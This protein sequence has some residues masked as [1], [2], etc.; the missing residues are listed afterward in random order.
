MKRDH[1]QAR[2]LGRDSTEPSTDPE[3]RVVVARDEPYNLI[4]STVGLPVGWHGG[5]KRDQKDD[6]LHMPVL[7][8]DHMC[9][10]LPS[11]H[12]PGHFHLYIDVP[13]TWEQYEN[14]IRALAAG[15]VIEEGY[16][17]VSLQRQ[18]TFVAPRPW[19]DVH[20]GE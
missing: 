15:G 16:A 17:N 1:Y 3:N 7:D 19:K 12:T 14:I 10:L 4:G 5:R 20:D 13:M 6:V 18:A 9:H 2:D 11:P 8:I